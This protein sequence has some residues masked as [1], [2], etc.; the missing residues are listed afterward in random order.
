MYQIHLHYLQK[1]HLD[2]L[3]V[4]KN[5]LS[6]RFLANCV[7]PSSMVQVVYVNNETNSHGQYFADCLNP[8]IAGSY[9]QFAEDACEGSS[10]V[11]VPVTSPMKKDF[12]LSMLF[13]IKNF[14][15]F[16]QYFILQP[17]APARANSLSYWLTQR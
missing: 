16:R 15:N 14:K 10:G 8:V 4:K 17:I 3:L 6:K 9:W 7:C 11:L 1:F 5:N 13:C 12:I 2:L